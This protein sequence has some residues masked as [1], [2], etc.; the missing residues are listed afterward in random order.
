MLAKSGWVSIGRSSLKIIIEKSIISCYFGINK[1]S[2]NPINFKFSEP[3]SALN[4]LIIRA[5]DFIGR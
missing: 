1:G 3:N 4:D 2:K 5:Q